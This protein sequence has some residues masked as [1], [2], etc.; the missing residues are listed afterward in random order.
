MKKVIKKLQKKLQK[1]PNL[2]IAM[3]IVLL[4]Q[5]SPNPSSEL[6]Y[7]SDIKSF[8]KKHWEKILDALIYSDKI[9]RINLV[10]EI[11]DEEI[12]ELEKIEKFGEF[13]RADIDLYEKLKNF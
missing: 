1:D 12:S 11:F 4:V 9:K 2:D 5:D 10:E 6:F 13:G 8:P 3:E 7:D